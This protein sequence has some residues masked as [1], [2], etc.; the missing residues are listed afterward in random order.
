MRN[1]KWEKRSGPVGKRNDQSEFA[2][3]SA[4][5]KMSRKKERKEGEAY[6]SFFNSLN[7]GRNETPVCFNRGGSIKIR[8]VIL[9][10][11]VDPFFKPTQVLPFE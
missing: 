1:A 10:C 11:Q 4:A 7:V 9:E 2:Y 6:F 8:H 3:F 5:V